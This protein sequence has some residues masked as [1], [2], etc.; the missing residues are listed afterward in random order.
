MANSKSKYTPRG[1][2]EYILD[3]VVALEGTN[4]LIE[5]DCGLGK[6]FLTHQIV[7][8]KF[9]TKRFIIVVHSSSSLAE[10]IDYLRGEYGGLE[11]DLGEIS[12]RV[13]SGLRELVLKEKRVIVATPQTLDR[14]LQ[15]KIELVDDIDAVIINEVDTLIK[16]TSVRTAIVFPWT[17]LLS[18]LSD[19][20]LIG[21]SGTLRDDHAVF[22]KEQMEIRKEI[23]T[24]KKFIPESEVL[25]MDDLYDTDI[26]EYLE[27]TFLSIKHV[28]DTKIQSISKVI[29]ELIRNVR[30]EIFKELKEND[31]LDL[32]D[33]DTRR[34]HLLLE[35]L[36]VSD[37]LKGRYS[38]L[39]MIRKYVYAMPPKQFLK[40]FYND[41][42]KHYFNVK[43]LKKVL[44][45]ISSKALKVVEIAVDH[46]KTL[47]LSSYLEMVSQIREMLKNAGIESLEITGHTPD[48]GEVL[49]RFREDPELKALV[50][51]PVGE[52]DLDI[53]Q[54]DVMVVC[55]TIN[56]TKTMYQKFK[57]TRGGL[58]YLL[59]YAGTSEEL[60]VNRLMNRI[61]ERYPWST[62]LINNSQK[63]E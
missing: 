38:G 46:E 30:R 56:T 47:V 6:R 54:A 11:E 13:R 61:L 5:L 19:K 43:E 18:H 36:P 9:P 3:R 4:L 63:M 32:I 12:S 49:K 21:M 62:A 34:I 8:E 58:V 27:P 59:T 7:Q 45:E 1:Y 29:D 60:K 17:T 24:L 52:R 35:R 16:R 10:T 31:N 57:R 48:K 44:P 33:G 28:S 14:L 15:K 23:M 51:S 42:L 25:T 22:S 53:P 55:D 37:E 2:Q 39:L 41:Y 20:W 26:M 40:M 50:M